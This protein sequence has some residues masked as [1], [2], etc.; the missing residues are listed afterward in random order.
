MKK[1]YIA[2]SI[3]DK[4]LFRIFPAFGLI[5][6]LISIILPSWFKPL[7]NVVVHNEVIYQL[8]HMAA[9]MLFILIL[10][11]PGRFVFYAVIGLMFSIYLPLEQAE[12]FYSFFFYCIF[13]F[14]L[15]EMELFEKYRKLKFLGVCFYYLF[16]IFLQFLFYG[17]SFFL[18]NLFQ[19]VVSFSLIV[20]TLVLSLSVQKI[21][22][23]EVQ[24]EPEIESRGKALDLGTFERF[25]EREIIIICKI[26]QNEKYDYIARQLGLSE[27]TVKKAAGGIFKKM[28]CTDKFDF[29][30]KY[31]NLSVVID[32]KVY[33]TEKR[34]ETEI[35]L[36]MIAKEKK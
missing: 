30:G 35:L 19:Y 33:L 13:L 17:F 4:I 29:F 1:R 32:D 28:D 24:K 16:I 11:F 34:E 23:E 21:T 6:S 5:V 8:I 7:G 9:S 25:S 10:V 12:V 15:Y 2:E 31:S 18:S 14:S 22:A 20:L 26:L 36:E 3:K 27:I